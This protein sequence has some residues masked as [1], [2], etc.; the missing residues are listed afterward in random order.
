MLCISWGFRKDMLVTPLHIRT[1][2]EAAPWLGLNSSKCSLPSMSGGCFIDSNE[3]LRW[4]FS[5][6]SYELL[7]CLTSWG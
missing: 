5:R 2:A 6:T 3:D 1:L 4:S 7:G